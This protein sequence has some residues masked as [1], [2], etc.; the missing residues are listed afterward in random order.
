V[1]ND[2]IFIS[3]SAM[4]VASYSLVKCNEAS[5]IDQERIRTGD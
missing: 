5:C 3:L 2:V 1:H 4:K